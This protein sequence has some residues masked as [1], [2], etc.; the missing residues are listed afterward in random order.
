MKIRKGFVSNSSSS[1]FLIYGA[2]VSIDDIKEEVK[3][4]LAKFLEIDLDDIEFPYDIVRYINKKENIDLEDHDGYAYDFYIGRSWDSIGDDETGKQFKDSI[5]NALKKYFDCE[6]NTI[7][8][9][10]YDG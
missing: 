1:S 10:F 5:E 6:C 4:D 2:Q 3:E 8:E 9:C 7:E